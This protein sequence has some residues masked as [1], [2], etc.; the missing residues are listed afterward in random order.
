LFA[1]RFTAFVDACVLAGALKRN[2]LLSLAEAGFFRVRW[3]A[4]VLGETQEA[5]ARIL[6][7]DADGR[8]K[9]KQARNAMAMAFEEAMV[10]DYEALK[11]VC[12]DLPDPDD[13]HVVAAA[14]KC[15]AAVI[16]TD[17]LKDFPAE[18]VL[19]ANI[20]VRSADDFI[21]DT[22]ALHPGRAVSAIRKMRQRFN[23]PDI[24][25]PQLLLKLEGQGLIETANILRPHVD[26]L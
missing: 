16:V 4:E 25:P 2:L 24:S 15:Q 22:I 17:N 11:C 14:I 5:I 12:N 7:G 8:E 13:Q 21:A 9:A 10:E 3:S 19:R 23:R 1:N 20:E 26:S 6:V 18:I